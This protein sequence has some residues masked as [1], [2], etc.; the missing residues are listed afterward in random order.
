M[1]SEKLGEQTLRSDRI[2]N[3]KVI[4]LRRD[5]VKLP[6]GKTAIREV[7]EHQG[8][9]SIVAMPDDHTIVLVRQFRRP[10]MKMLLELPA[11]SLEEGESPEECASRELVEET[12]YRADSLVKIQKFFLAPGYST[13]VMHI[14]MATGLS[15]TDRRLDEEE[16]IEVIKVEFGEAVQMV[17]RGE[18]EDAKSICGILRADIMMRE[19]FRS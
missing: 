11:G 2:Y 1:N 6:I 17:M 16:D 14:F 3:G 10:S 19:E 9:V 8:G 5:M 4:N 18:I 12:G 15:E 7:V 13:E